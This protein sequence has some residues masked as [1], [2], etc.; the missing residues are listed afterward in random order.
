MTKAR[1]RVGSIFIAYESR[2][3]PVP[4]DPVPRPRSERSIIETEN[5]SY[6]FKQSKQQNNNSNPPKGGSTRPCAA[7]SDQTFFRRLRTRLSPTRPTPN[8]AKLAGST[9]R[10]ELAIPR[11]LATGSILV[12]AFEV[13]VARRFWF[14]AP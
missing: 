2:P 14:S 7:H 10:V 3:D 5:E 1:I 8:K 13:S 12:C 6:R 9:T 4:R 11:G